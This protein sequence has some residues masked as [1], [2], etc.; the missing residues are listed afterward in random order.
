MIEKIPLPEQVTK[1]SNYGRS[2]ACENLAERLATLFSKMALST[3]KYTE[4]SGVLKALVDDFGQA[5]TLG[6]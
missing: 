2:R 6:D 1:E 3:K 5:M 4:P